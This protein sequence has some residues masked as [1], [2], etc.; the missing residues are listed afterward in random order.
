MRRMLMLFLATLLAAVQ[1]P[2][3]TTVWVLR[4]AEKVDDGSRD[5]ALSPEGITR[6]AA[7]AALLSEED[8]AAVFTTPYERTR[9]TVRPLAEA[10]ELELSPYD[11]VDFAGLASRVREVDGDVVIVGHSN[12]VIPIVQ[13]LGGDATGEI[14]ESEYGRLYKVVI[15][16]ETVTTEQLTY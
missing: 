8:V 7:L 2:A 10:E 6:A 4:H 3:A 16:G 5:P 13:A 1:L 9:A 11:P 14:G 12:T 15:D